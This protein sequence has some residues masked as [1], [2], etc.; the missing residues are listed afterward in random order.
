MNDTARPPAAP[1]PA[2]RRLDTIAQYDAAFDDLLGR[3]RSEV[4]L[5]DIALQPSFD[6]PA[7]AALLRA[8]L[9]GNRN[10]RLRILL[11]DARSVPVHCPRLCALLRRF[12]DAVGIHQTTESARSAADP[13]LVVD[14]VHALRRVHHAASRSVLITDD[15]AAVRPLHARLA[16]IHEASEPALAATVLGL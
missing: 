16:Q 15:T 8:F 12:S 9:S 3:A 7:R 10:A 6:R 11:H 4:W 1:P 13:L 2:Y 14:A 5:F